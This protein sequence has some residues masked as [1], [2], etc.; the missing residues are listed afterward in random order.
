MKE[1]HIVDLEGRII[2]SIIVTDDRT[3]VMPLYEDR[4][5][6]EE[7]GQPTEIIVGYSIAERVPEGLYQPRWDFSAYDGYQTAVMEARLSYAQ[8]Y[9]DWSQEDEE[10]RG[11][12][13]VLTLPEAP[14]FWVEGLTQAEIDALHKP[15]P[16]DPTEQR[17]A[18]LE[19]ALADLFT[20]GI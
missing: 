7:G 2:E 19:L 16:I 5:P 13:P 4:A 3:G 1:A 17:L 14:A 18:D 20:G 9:S 15:Q 6:E 12:A 10:T 11:D 8:A